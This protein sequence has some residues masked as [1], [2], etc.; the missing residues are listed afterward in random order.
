MGGICESGNP[1]STWNFGN[2]TG[3]LSLDVTLDGQ[4]GANDRNATRNNTNVAAQ[5]L[6]DWC[7][8]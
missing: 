4:V 6:A 5:P 3:Y 2:Q 1:N 7:D 8:W